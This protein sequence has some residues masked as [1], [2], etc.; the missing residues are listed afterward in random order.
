VKALGGE[1]E[2]VSHFTP[3]DLPEIVE[4]P[5]YLS[6]LGRGRRGEVGNLPL[7]LLFLL[8]ALVKQII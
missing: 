3:E 7:P 5:F 6:R 1:E 4:N 2:S 8:S